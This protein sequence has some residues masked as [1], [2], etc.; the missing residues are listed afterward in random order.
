[1]VVV[2]FVDA[3]VVFI[4]LHASPSVLDSLEGVRGR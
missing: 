3:A 1:M 4:H 2:L